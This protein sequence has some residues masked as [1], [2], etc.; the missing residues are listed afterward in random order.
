[1]GRMHRTK[2]GRHKK[3]DTANE[4]VAQDFYKSFREDGTNLLIPSDYRVIL[5]KKWS[6]FCKL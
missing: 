4:S 1:M 2:N 6:E 5:E 3:S